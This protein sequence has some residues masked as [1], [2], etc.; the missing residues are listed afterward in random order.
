M[1][2][3]ALVIVAVLAAMALAAITWSKPPPVVTPEHR[4]AAVRVEAVV[5]REERRR[6]VAQPTVETEMVEATAAFVRTGD[7]EWVIA[8]ADIYA[9][10]SFP[11]YRPNPIVAARL[12]TMASRGGNTDARSKFAGAFGRAMA[13]ED[14]AG[15]E[16]PAAWASAMLDEATR[17]LATARRPQPRPPPPPPP[18]PPPPPP[19]IPSDGQNVHDHGVVAATRKTID[20]LRSEQGTGASVDDIREAFDAVPDLSDAERARADMVLTSLTTSEHSRLGVSE[21]EA[22]SLVYDRLRGTD[23]GVETLAK[24]LASAIEAG[25][26]V[27]STGKIARMVG[28]LDGVCDDVTTAKPLWAVREELASLAHKV[29]ERVLHG[30]GGHEG[31]EEIM[32]HTFRE[33]A[34]ETYVDGLGMSASVVDPLV[35]ALVS[36][37]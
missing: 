14:M 34:R 24:Q 9:R 5:C 7:W 27:C 13:P 33:A 37:F 20:M 21:S 10:G 18:R 3:A 25:D 17:R 12:Y 35:E 2:V 19:T 29:R 23:H 6:E 31:S 11:H 4:A 22:V 32:V 28:A 30:S 1:V 15:D 36:G 8:A 16:V 26:V